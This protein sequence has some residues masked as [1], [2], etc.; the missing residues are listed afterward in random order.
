MYLVQHCIKTQQIFR[1]NSAK[2]PKYSMYV[3]DVYH[4]YYITVQRQVLLG[5]VGSVRGALVASNDSVRWPVQLLSPPR[6]LLN[7]AERATAQ[8]AT[9]ERFCGD[10]SAR[11]DPRLPVCH[12]RKRRPRR[13]RTGL[14]HPH[15]PDQQGRLIFFRH[16]CGRNPRKSRA[17]FGVNFVIKF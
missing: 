17:H 12:R 3:A 5:Q 15:A 2:S 10:P 16:F 7:P 11:D 8:A 9:A 4:F 6:L 1:K 14:S 13:T